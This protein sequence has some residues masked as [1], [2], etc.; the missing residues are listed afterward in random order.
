MVCF[1]QAGVIERCSRRYKS[2]VL[3]SGGTPCLILTT[4]PMTLAILQI[5]LRG[6]KGRKEALEKLL[7]RFLIS[8][9]VNLHYLD[10]TGAPNA[11]N[12]TQAN[13]ERRPLFVYSTSPGFQASASHEAPE[14]LSLA[15]GKTLSRQHCSDIA[16][17]YLNHVHDMKESGRF[18]Q[19]STA[20]LYRRSY[21]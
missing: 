20:G 8:L 14:G 1:H 9:E 18:C 7:K 16:L 17:S 21:G 3:A 4:T 15:S 11:R 6:K 2:R 13:S 5:R 12:S 19:F 10:Q